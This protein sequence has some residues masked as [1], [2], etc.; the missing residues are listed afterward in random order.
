M[1]IEVDIVRWE[2]NCCGTPFAV[3][4]QATWHLHAVAPESGAPSRFVSDEHDQTP[5]D[6]PH[7]AVTGTVAAITGVSYPRIP[8]PG[9]IGTSTSDLSRPSMQPLTSVDFPAEGECSEF[10]VLLDVPD[11]TP[12]PT[13]RQGADA[14]T[15]LSRKRNAATVGRQRMTDEVGVL[16]EALADDAQNRYAHLA[17]AIRATDKSA[18]TLQP[19]R[20]DAAAISWTRSSAPGNDGITV[21]VGDGRWSFPATRADAAIVREFLDAAVTGRVEEHVVPAEAPHTLETE[22][23]AQDGRSWT[24]SIE[25]APFTTGGVM[26]VPRLLWDRV[27]RGEYRYAAWDIADSH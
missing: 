7:W 24:A 23:R 22:V 1:Q 17:V 6:V 15:Q 9:M 4:G 16:L 14:T 5:A 26:A 21:Q 25:F 11:G 3:G 13:H 12:L 19:G 20:T 10:R 2:H 18:V 27:Q 8:M